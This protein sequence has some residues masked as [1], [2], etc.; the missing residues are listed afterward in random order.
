VAGQENADIA[1]T[2]QGTLPRQTFFWLSIYVVHIGATRRIRLNRP[3][4]CGGDAALSQITLTSC[5][6]LRL[7]GK[8]AMQSSLAIPAC[9]KRVAID[10]MQ[11]V[12]FDPQRRPIV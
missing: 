10:Y 1:D 4:A 9:L 2:L 5:F 12:T 8:F 3:C 11:L 7:T 6:T